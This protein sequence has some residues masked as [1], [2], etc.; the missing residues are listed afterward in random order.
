MAD[1]FIGQ[2]TTAPD[3][4]D[5]TEPV[6]IEQ[7]D[8]TYKTTTQAIANLANLS[9][10]LEVSVAAGNASISASDYQTNTFFLITGATGSPDVTRTITLPAVKRLAAFRSSSANTRPVILSYGSPAQTTTVYPGSSVLIYTDSTATGFYRMTEE[11]Y[12]FGFSLIG[13]SSATQATVGRTVIPRAAIIPA[14]CAGSFGYIGTNPSATV[15][16][17][18]RL[19]G[20]SIGTISISTGGV[21]TFTTASNTPVTIT[22][23]NRIEFVR[24]SSPDVT[25]T[26]AAVTVAAYPVR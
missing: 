14:S 15:T 4:L 1:A 10:A 8:E 20:A 12:D 13:S 25:I 26:D 7:D 2:L 16:I 19:E 9:A 17:D 11:V 5:G 6:P 22:A 18:I 21:F 23:G 24:T 3:A